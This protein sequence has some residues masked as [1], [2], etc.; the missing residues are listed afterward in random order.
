MYFNFEG[1]LDK[2]DPCL[3]KECVG[4]RWLGMAI[5][6]MPVYCA[7]GTRPPASIGQCCPSMSNCPGTFQT[8]GFFGGGCHELS[9]ESL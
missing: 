8:W 2:S 1:D 6:C 9:S 3:F 4:G 7:D 5:A